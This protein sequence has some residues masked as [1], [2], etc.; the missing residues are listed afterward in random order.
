[1]ESWLAIDWNALFSLSMAPAEIIVRGSAMYWFLFLMFRFVIRRDVGSVGL[2]DV[3]VLVI[4]ADAAQNAMS[5][6]YKSVT[7]GMLLVA[8]LIGWN[9]LLDWMSYRYPWFRRLA[10]PRP[11]TLVSNGCVLFRN[12]RRELIT[13]EELW[14][15]LRENGIESL[16][17]VRHA[18]MEADG[19]ISVIKKN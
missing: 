3:L 18:F 4:V 2:A 8:V 12:L 9:F 11:L 6:E 19:Q 17:Q 10:E 1:M 7:D 14:G 15:K 5:G 13:E 16:D